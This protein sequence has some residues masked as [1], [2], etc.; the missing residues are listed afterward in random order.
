MLL[1]KCRLFTSVS[2]MTGFNDEYLSFQKDVLV[3]SKGKKK[4]VAFRYSLLINH[5]KYY[6][7]VTRP[8]GTVKS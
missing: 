4:E 2:V 7:S 3:K 6:D 8:L 5:V 1:T